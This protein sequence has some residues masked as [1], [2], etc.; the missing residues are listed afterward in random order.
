FGKGIT[1]EPEHPHRRVV[2]PGGL[3]APRQCNVD[4]MGNL[5]CQFMKSQ[6]RNEADHPGRDLPGDYHKIR[7][8]ERR[9]FCESIQPPTELLEYTCVTHG[10][11]RPRMDTE[12]QSL[13]GP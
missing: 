10:V 5:G 2:E 6:G 13:A 9:E 3:R 4:G 1:C 8:T 11:K 7:S 12:P